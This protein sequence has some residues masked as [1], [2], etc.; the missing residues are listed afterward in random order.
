MPEL[1]SLA[2]GCPGRSRAAARVAARR[3]DARVKRP[4]DPTPATPDV[5]ARATESAIRTYVAGP[6]LT[7]DEELLRGELSVVAEYVRMAMAGDVPTPSGEAQLDRLRLLRTLRAAVIEEWTQDDDALLATMRAF[8]STE[9]ALSEGDEHASP[10]DGLSPFSRNVLREVSHLLRSP[11]GSIVMLTETLREERAGPLSEAQRHQLDIIYRAALSAAA[12][13]SDLLVLTSREERYESARR[14]SIAETVNTVADV[15]RPVTAARYSELVVH[16]NDERYRMGPTAAV[17]EALLGL[18]L[19]AALMTREGTVE[20][21]V[22]SDEGDILS[23]SVTSRGGGA[24]GANDRV[25]LLQ[26]FRADPGS[27]SYTI[28]PEGLAFSA[29]RETIRA[30]GSELHVDASPDGVLTMLFRIA[31]PLAD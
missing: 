1:R 11:L 25:D 26:V 28:S 23:F 21:G 31:L 13:A 22:S 5:L 6:L 14:F 27:A 12:T 3:H 9:R 4:S 10:T 30:I 2:G 18:A 7:P 20:L 16:N 24:E 17:G 19:R 8:E 15:V 29:A